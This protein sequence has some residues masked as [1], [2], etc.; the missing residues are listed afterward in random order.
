M[1]REERESDKIS[2]VKKYLQQM[3]ISEG[4]EWKHQQ[5]SLMVVKMENKS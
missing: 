3:K 1:A 2:E 4:H 5:V